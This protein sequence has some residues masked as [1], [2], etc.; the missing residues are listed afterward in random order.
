LQDINWAWENI[1]CN[2]KISTKGS[3][4]AHERKEQKTWFDKERP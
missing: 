3:V 1:R 4:H 2:I